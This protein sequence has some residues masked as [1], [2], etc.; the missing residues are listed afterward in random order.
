MRVDPHLISWITDYLTMR[1]QFVRLQDCVSE[2]VIS[3]LARL[4]H[5]E[6]LCLR[7]FTLNM[8]DFRSQD[9]ESC[10]MQKFSDN[11]AIVA[12]IRDGQEGE[13]RSLVKDFVDGAGRIICC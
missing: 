8:S 7:L 4:L 12:G 2:T 5:K 11:T 13:Y 3:S 6:L 9:T 1:T 10:H